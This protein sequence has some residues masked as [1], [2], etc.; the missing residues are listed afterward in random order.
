MRQTDK[1][2]HDRQP[3]ETYTDRPRAQAPVRRGV[4]APRG[5][6]ARAG[7]CEKTNIET[8]S[9]LWKIAPRPL[10][11]HGPEYYGNG[12]RGEL[13]NRKA[14]DAEGFTTELH[15]DQQT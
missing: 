12:F 11:A 5:H 13:A 9:A 3:R 2:W 6:Q 8:S 10:F 1:W 4:P 7:V 14:A 15:K